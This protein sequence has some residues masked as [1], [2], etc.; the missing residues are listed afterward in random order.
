M[1]DDRT[2]IGDLLVLAVMITIGWF[3]NS[4]DESQLR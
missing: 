4:I 2:T 3:D 1:S